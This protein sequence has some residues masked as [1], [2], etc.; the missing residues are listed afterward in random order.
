[1]YMYSIHVYTCILVCVCFRAG[2]EI[3]TINLSVCS[4]VDS[5]IVLP[6]TCTGCYRCAL[7]KQATFVLV[8]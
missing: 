8:E 7:Y 6:L 5:G 3:E 2:I 4:H 1:M